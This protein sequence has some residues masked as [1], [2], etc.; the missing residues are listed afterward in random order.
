MN[1]KSIFW[2]VII[3][4]YFLSFVALILAAYTFWDNYFNFKL[5]IAVGRQVKLG[6]LRADKGKTKP[7][8]LMS[9]AFT[10]SGGKTEYLDDTKLRVTLTSNNR[11]QWE[12]EFKSIS[13]YDAFFTKGSAI[14]QVELLPLVIIGKTT[15]I[16]KYVFASVDDVQQDQIP[17]AFDLGIKVYTKQ[18]GKWKRQ[19]E[20]EIR[21]V[22]DVW[23]SPSNQ[24][25]WMFTIKD[26]FEKQ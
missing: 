6:L 11:S 17:E 10:N 25:E 4:P 1:T 12:K 19:K 2:K 5:D 9:L 14:K 23:Q 20:Y 16:K 15:E 3:S 22:S 21:N 18:R 24:A 26:V 8:I 13:E 7:I